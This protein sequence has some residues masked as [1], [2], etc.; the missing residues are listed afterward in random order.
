[1]RR[2]NTDSETKDGQTGQGILDNVRLASTVKGGG[3]AIV[4]VVVRRLGDPE[5]ASTSVAL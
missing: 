3:R 2:T 5:M 1:M 4:L